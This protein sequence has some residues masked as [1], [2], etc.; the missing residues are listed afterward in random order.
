MKTAARTLLRLA[1]LSASLPA[2]VGCAAKPEPESEPPLG[3]VLADDGQLYAGVARMDIT[4][5]IVETYTDLNGNN[6]FDGCNTDPTGTRAGCDEPYD[7]V[8]GDGHFDGVWIA[9]YQTHRAA[10][11]VHDPITVGAV[12][13]SLNGDYVALVG[14]DVLGLLENRTRDVRDTLEA[15]GF[16]R[17]HLIIS[18]SHSHSAPDTVGIWGLD[19]QL[20]S[21]TYA[22]FMDDLEANI[23]DTVRLAAGNMVAVSPTQGLLSMSADPTLDGAPFGGT[24]PNDRM[25][26]GINDIR[27]P[28]LPADQVWALALDGAD[29][30]VATVISSSGHPEVAG[31]DHSLLSSDF[32]GYAR[33]TIDASAGGTTLYLSGALGGM[34]SAAGSTLPTLDEQGAR[35]LDDAGQ[36]V[37]MED[38]EGWEAARTWG[39]LV[40]QTAEAALTDTT[41]WDAIDIRTQGLLIPV[42]N[43]SFKLAFQTH[44]LDTPDEYVVRDASCPG[45][46][47]D[48][49]LFGCVPGAIW[50]IGLG[51]NTLATAP[52]ELLP[53]LFYGVPDEP[54]MDD[55]A[56]RPT[57]RRWVQ[58]PAA[59]ADVDYAECTTTS[60]VG[61]CD[62]LHAHAAPYRLSD[63]GAGSIADLI[64]GTYKVPLGITNAYCGYIVPAPDFNTYVSVLTPDNGDH[65]EE[66]NSCSKDFAPLLQDAWLALADAR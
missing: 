50:Q 28:I 37:W 23:E 58:A 7:D 34:Q 61:D 25:L 15:E 16:H 60:N 49:D 20:L 33:D 18:S 4:P 22:P 63:T 3:M 21:G 17:D 26:G 48:T 57:D 51:P 32:V 40:A 12:V 54:A 10:A 29:G 56:L 62:C 41:A 59:C 65:Y 55:A 6:E 11:G 9:G 5:E 35:V 14:I 8:N 30:R 52:G 2:W 64:P 42:N 44:L 19:E 13:L 27:D 46:G 43:I 1:L 53:E 45:W 38:A 24:N 39:V 31:S 66:T 36:P 47:T